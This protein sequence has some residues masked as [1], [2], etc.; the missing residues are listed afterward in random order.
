[1]LEIL[2]HSGSNTPPQERALPRG[3]GNEAPR[4]PHAAYDLDE[5]PQFTSSM[6]HEL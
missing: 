5:K 6:V 1:M 4:P 3:Q 2:S